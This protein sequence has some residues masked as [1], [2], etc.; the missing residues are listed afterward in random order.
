MKNKNILA[1]QNLLRCL[2]MASLMDPEVVANLVRAFGIMNWGPATTGPEARFIGSNGAAI[3]QT[4]DQIA[5]AL[6]YLS[7]FK[8]D[9][10]CEIGVMH[11][12]N[13]LF[14]SEY[15][16]RFNPDI[17]CLGV[18][19]T[20]YLDA[21]IRAIIET[22]MFLTFKSVTS[23]QIVGQ[24]FDFVFIDGDHVS[25]WPAQDY[26]NVG[27]YAKI[28]G[29]HD[30]QDLLWPDVAALWEG[31]KGNKK[32]V[33]VEFIDDLSGSRSHGIGLIHDKGIA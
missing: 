14:V 19:P 12:G 6:V 27:Q 2:D 26:E 25:P 13:F 23:A 32:K 33:M 20:N 29:F 31:L 28:C 5:K 21:E 9:S 10:F 1:V 8:I 30:L 22:E 7:Q 4:P 17:Q 16:R 24:E 11:G 18:D 15:L 3:G